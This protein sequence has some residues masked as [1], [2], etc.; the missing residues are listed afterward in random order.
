MAQVAT[1][2]AGTT[3]VSPLK[4]YYYATNTNI[5]FEGC[6]QFVINLPYNTHFITVG[7]V[8]GGG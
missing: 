3:K 6:R 5:D 8:D 1:M 7:Q 4:I 2:I